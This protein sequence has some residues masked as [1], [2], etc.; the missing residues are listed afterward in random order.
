MRGTPAQARTSGI[1]A[2]PDMHTVKRE[3]AMKTGQK[4]VSWAGRDQ[5]HYLPTDL[6]IL[7]TGRVG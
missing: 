2:S 1:A 7:L 6:Q 5:I 4:G 3:M